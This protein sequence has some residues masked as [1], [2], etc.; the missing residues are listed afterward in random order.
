MGKGGCGWLDEENYTT[1]SIGNAMH[2][3][4]TRTWTK[5]RKTTVF[6]FCSFAK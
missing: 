5:E 1:I 6:F 2:S 3:H 4:Q